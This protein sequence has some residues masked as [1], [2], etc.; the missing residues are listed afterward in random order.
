MMLLL[1]VIYRFCYDGF[2]YY[3]DPRTKD[4]FLSGNP[5]LLFALL[6]VY[7]KFVTNWGPRYMKDRKPFQ[8]KL[9]LT[10][11]NLVQIF[12]SIRVVHLCST[13]V[14]FFGSYNLIC[15]PVD[16][17][18]SELGL[19][20]ASE[21]QKFFLL[22]VFDLLDTV[23]F[24]LRKKQKQVTFLHLYHHIG[25]V[26][27]GL[28]AVMFIPGGH[29]ASVGYINAIVHTFMYSY[30]LYALYQRGSQIWWKKY[31]TLL[32]IAQFSILSLHWGIMV[33]SPSCGFPKILAFFF[34][35]QNMF[36]LAMFLQFYYK[37]YIKN[38]KC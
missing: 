12:L 33:I 22:K 6:T 24:V 16:Y 18:N 25:M 15:E 37:A 29:V 17:T 1:K 21:V 7:Y 14:Y 26:F 30:Y 13:K 38:K 28:Y 8:L 32:Q 35:P 27:V 36:M 4:Y 10:A 20:A 34:F 9:V 3:R 5:L 2:N 23:F 11:Y 19:L 31:I